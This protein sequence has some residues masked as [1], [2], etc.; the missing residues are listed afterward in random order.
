M[1]EKSVQINE[2]DELMEEKPLLGQINF[3]EIL[4]EIRY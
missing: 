4:A 3:E 1:E 2:Q